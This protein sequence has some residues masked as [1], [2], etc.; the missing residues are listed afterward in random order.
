M[1]NTLGGKDT[2]AN[3]SFWDL[4]PPFVDSGLSRTPLGSLDRRGWL[5]LKWI[6]DRWEEAVLLMRRSVD[7]GSSSRV[8]V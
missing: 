2:P 4:H 1:D 3:G 6:L 5:C 8:T 7:M